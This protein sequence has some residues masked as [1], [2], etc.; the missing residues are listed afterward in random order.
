[1]NREEATA[2]MVETFCRLTPAQKDNLMYHRRQ[3]TPILRG[4]SW[5][6]FEY[7]GAG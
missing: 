2:I 6:L 1:M 5:A 7:E 3:K 4:G